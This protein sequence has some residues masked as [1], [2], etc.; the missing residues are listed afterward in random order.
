MFVKS[1][2]PPMSEEKLEIELV[3]VES[4][5][6][7]EH[8]NSGLRQMHLYLLGLSCQL[9]SLLLELLVPV[10]PSTIVNEYVSAPELLRKSRFT[11]VSVGAVP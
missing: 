4:V 2:V 5:C 6:P 11:T 8:S 7:L 3:I 1:S 10:I 9:S